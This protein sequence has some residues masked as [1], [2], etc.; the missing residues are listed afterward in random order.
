MV[1]LPDDRALL[2]DKK[3]VLWICEPE[4]QGF[5]CGKYMTLE[6]VYNRD[7]VGLLSIL[8]SD[9][10]ES[11]KTVDFSQRSCETYGH[12]AHSPLS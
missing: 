1:F 11:G 10:W 5:P 9:K 12:L 6:N 8:I 3:G 7:E 2:I 4:K